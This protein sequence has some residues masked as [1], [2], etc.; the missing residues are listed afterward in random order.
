MDYVNMAFKR[1]E[2]NHVCYRFAIDVA[3]GSLSSSLLWRRGGEGAAVNRSAPIQIVVVP[4][5]HDP[6]SR[7]HLNRR[8]F[9]SPGLPP[10]VTSVPPLADHC[11]AASRV[12]PGHHLSRCLLASPIPRSNITGEYLGSQSAL[13]YLSPD[14]RGENLLIGAN[15]ASAGVS[16]LND[17]GIQFVSPAFA[18]ASSRQFAIQDYAPYLIS[19]YKKICTVSL[20][21]FFL[22]Q[23]ILN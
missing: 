8:R 11:L 17:T 7:R 16:N 19:E 10:S 2:K 12:P 23:R 18:T 20:P 13:P 1:L 14:L 9:P 4:S 5:S 15:F 21:S 3:D 22:L 6:P